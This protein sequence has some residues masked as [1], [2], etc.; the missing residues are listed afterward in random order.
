[1]IDLKDKDRMYAL[2][3][4]ENKKKI[5]NTVD[6]AIDAKRQKSPNE[7][8]KALS[9]ITRDAVQHFT[10]EEIFMRNIKYPGYHYHRDEHQDFSVKAFAYSKLILDSDS[11]IANKILKYLKMWLVKHF[12]EADKKYN[13]YFNKNEL[14]QILN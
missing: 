3:I 11:K 14:K 8:K 4:N 2:L 1:M 12:Q 7:L 10:I 5:I 13:E 9:H 6:R